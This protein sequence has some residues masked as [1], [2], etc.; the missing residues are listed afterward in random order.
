MSPFRLAA[1][2]AAIDILQ[3]KEVTFPRK[4]CS[5]CALVILLIIDRARKY[6]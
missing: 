4:S 1:M 2:A 5:S 6:M 3:Q